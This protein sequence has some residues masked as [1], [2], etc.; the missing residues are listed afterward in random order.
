[1]QEL[2]ARART[3][4][5]ALNAARARSEAAHTRIAQLDTT[6]QHERRSA[7]EK[8][9]ELKDAHSRLSAEFKALSAEAL[10]SNNAAFLDLAH[11]AFGRL[12]QQFS[13]DL[14]KRQ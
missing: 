8:L 5:E 12:Q 4:E 13:G 3:T 2:T 6:L 7:E 9:A 1:M 11:E 10:K 14:E